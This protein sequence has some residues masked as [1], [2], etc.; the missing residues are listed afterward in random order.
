MRQTRPELYDFVIF[1][2]NKRALGL[3]PKGTSSFRGEQV[4]SEGNKL[5][6]NAESELSVLCSN[7]CSFGS[8]FAH[9]EATFRIWKQLYA[10]GS[11][12]LNFC[13]H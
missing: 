5:L 11:R 6:P 10:L 8:K 9:S 2:V 1:I 12:I 3:L 4:A 7:F 13:S